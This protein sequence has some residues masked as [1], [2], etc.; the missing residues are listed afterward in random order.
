MRFR[1]FD[2]SVQRSTGAVELEWTVADCKATFVAHVVPG[3]AGLLLNRPDLK[4][5]RGSSRLG[6]DTLHL[7]KLDRTVELKET[8]A[9]H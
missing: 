1:G 6:A 7:A 4:S 8:K 5:H 2:D 9:G 3:N